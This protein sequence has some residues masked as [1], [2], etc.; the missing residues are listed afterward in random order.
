MTHT[1]FYPGSFD[2]LTNGHVDI[3]TRALGLVDRLVIGIGVHAGK[4]PL[5]TADTRR[6]LIEGVIAPLAKAAGTDVDLVE[7]DGLVVDAARQAGATMLIRGLRDTTDFDYE[8]RMANMNH[9]L[10]PDIETIFLAASPAM[11]FISSTLVRQIAA[12]GGDVSGFVPSPVVTALK[13]TMPLQK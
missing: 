2:P 10:A 6:Q 12:M 13:E 5:L 4:T 11:S 3:V 1:G 9:T 7:F 8:T